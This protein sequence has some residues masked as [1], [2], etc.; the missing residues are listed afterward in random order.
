M[1]SKG[2]IDCSF[3]NIAGIDNLSNNSP[4]SGFICYIDENGGLKEMNAD[5]QGDNNSTLRWNDGA[6]RINFYRHTGRTSGEYD[7]TKIGEMDGKGVLV[8]VLRKVKKNQGGGGR[9]K[10]EVYKP[11]A[12]PEIGGVI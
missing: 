3:V 5:E 11:N 9:D 12:V 8:N 10:K 7:F 2:K 4:R 6:S 1:F